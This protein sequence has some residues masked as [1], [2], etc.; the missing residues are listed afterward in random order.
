MIDFLTNLLATR[1]P[2]LL[3]IALT[4]ISGLIMPWLS[5]KSS[6]YKKINKQFIRISL[7]HLL[8]L[9]VVPIVFTAIG[10]LLQFGYLAIVGIEAITT[11][12]HA[13]LIQIIAYALMAGLSLLMFFWIIGKSKRM[14]LMMDKAAH[15][16]KKLK[17]NFTCLAIASI[18]LNFANLS[19]MGTPHQD[20][21]YRVALVISWLIQIWWLILVGIVIWNASEYVYSNIKVTM[22]DGQIYDFDCS[23]KVSRVYKNYI[24][25]R[26]RDEN[27]IV[28]QELQINEAAIKQIEYS[29]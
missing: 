10:I 4:L 25:I 14:K 18:M 24:R 20:M 7:L 6:N 12:L 9:S 1:W 8:Y 19:F 11:M 5:R 22:L 13:Y 17:T 26:K 3:G 23:P 15:I 2:E 29:K 27:N 21:A 28:V 16:N